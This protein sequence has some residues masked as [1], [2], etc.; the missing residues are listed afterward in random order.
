MSKPDEPS[1]TI[2]IPLEDAIDCYLKL[3]LGDKW[4]ER[5]SDD[6]MNLIQW[7]LVDRRPC[8][9]GLMKRAEEAYHRRETMHQQRKDGDRW[10]RNHVTVKWTD[11]LGTTVWDDVRSVHHTRRGVPKGTVALAEL[12]RELL[13]RFGRLD[14]PGSGGRGTGS[15]ARDPVGESAVL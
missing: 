10:V 12:E 2:E 6:E 1:S 5:I 15:S 9:E 11:Q 13:K 14:A 3:E 7:Y 8:P 4:I